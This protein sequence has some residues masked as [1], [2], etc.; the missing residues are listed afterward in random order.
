MLTYQWKDAKFKISSLND[1]KP[2]SA[3]D[4]LVIVTCPDP[5]GAD[6][7]RKLVS[8]LAEQDEANGIAPRPVVLFNQRLAG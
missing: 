7:C 6:E 1:R 2:V 8:Q 3:E 5:P 4:E